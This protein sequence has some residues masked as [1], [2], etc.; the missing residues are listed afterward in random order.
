GGRAAARGRERRGD[1]AA[2][3][4]GS[5]DGDRPDLRHDGRGRRRP[6]RRRARRRE[7]LLLLRRLPCPLP[8]RPGAISHISSGRDRV[9]PEIAALAAAME[10]Q[11][12]VAD[13][14]IATAL[15]L[16]QEMRRPLLVEGDAGVGKTEI[17]KVL[18]RILDTELIR[19]QCY[20]GLD[21]STA[22]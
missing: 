3:R 16:A 9:R 1:R 10:R 6:P 5:R 13:A 22:L 8:R 21:V 11:G 19:L 15:Y 18:A 12:Y 4:G 20:E 7:L 14:T 17:A 2:G